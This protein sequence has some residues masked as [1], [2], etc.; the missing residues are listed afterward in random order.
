MGLPFVSLFDDLA[1]SIAVPPVNRP[2][3]R[4]VGNFG[5][6]VCD[7]ISN[8]PAVYAPTVLQRPLLAVCQ[9]YWDQE[10]YSAPIIAPPFAGGQC[11]LA[12]SPRG[13]FERNC[14]EPNGEL[15]EWVTIGQAVGPVLGVVLDDNSYV[16]QFSGGVKLPIREPGQSFSLI[17]AGPG[18]ST[19]CSQLG[20]KATAAKNVKLLF[21]GPVGHDDT[22]GNPPDNVTPGPN[23]APAPEP[24]PPGT[25]PAINIRGIP[26]LVLPPTLRVSPT[27]DIELPDAEIN[28]G[29]GGK[30]TAPEPVLPGDD[31][32]GDNEP[33]GDGDT[34]FGEPPDGERWVGACV[35]ITNR[36]VGSGTIPQAEPQSI[37]PTTIGNVRL[38]F[39][40]FGPGPTEYDTPLLERQKTT[41]V[42]EPVRG[43]NSTGV[44]VNVIPGYSYVVT[45]YSVPKEQ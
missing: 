19:A 32:P 36:P 38:K 30:P 14:T 23:P 15:K 8:N 26:V 12:Y 11:A 3:A 27:L 34:D 17:S 31:I 28:L 6:R 10:G 42:W 45:P 4:G 7:G 21:A 41:C 35:T 22:C 20:A 39:K 44:R 37:Y 43:L 13:T 40:P 33:G 16:V 5:R 18:T 24:I 29:G 25:G 2:L 9:P 1:E